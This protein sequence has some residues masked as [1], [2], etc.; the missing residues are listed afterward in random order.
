MGTCCLLLWR[1]LWA[2]QDFAPRAVGDQAGPALAGWSHGSS[3]SL[4]RGPQKELVTFWTSRLKAA[5]GEGLA[6][7]ASE[8]AASK[9]SNPQ[10]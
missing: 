3:S 8:A 10:P 9:R 6:A 4:G 2:E 1:M 7:P 5:S